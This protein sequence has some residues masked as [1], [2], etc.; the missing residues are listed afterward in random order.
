MKK[1]FLNSFI[2][3]AALIFAGCSQTSPKTSTVNNNTNTRSNGGGAIIPANPNPNIAT[4]PISSPN[5]ANIYNRLNQLDLSQCVA[6]ADGY[7]H[8]ADFVNAM[9]A[10][11]YTCVRFQDIPT[12]MKLGH[13]FEKGEGARV[14]KVKALDIYQRACFGGYDPG[15][16]DMKRL[17]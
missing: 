4:S 16:K 7:Y 5:S 10:Y 13:M 8:D 14:D 12:C 9:L 1:K 3:F 2:I 6:V 15:C 11:D 17:Q